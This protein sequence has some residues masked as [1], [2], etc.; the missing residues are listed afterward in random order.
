MRKKC[1]A[2]LLVL[3]MVCALIVP[4]SATNK[5]PDLEGHWAKDNM[6]DLVD[7]GLLT[8]DS[9]GK[10]YP[11]NNTTTLQ[12]LVML[13]RFYD[14]D[15][16]TL[17][18]VHKEHGDYVESKVEP[19]LEWAYSA[20]EICLAAQ[21]VSEKELV[22]LKLTSP[23]NKQTLS[24]FLIR[25]MQMTD[26]TKE[27]YAPLTFEDTDTIFSSYKPFGGVLVDNGII[28]GDTQ[29]KFNPTQSVTR[30]VIATMLSRSLE[31]ME[32]KGIDLEL[33]GYAPTTQHTALLTKIIGDTIQIRDTAGVTFQ[34]NV[35]SN[36]KITQNGAPSTL[37]YTQ[38]GYPIA[39]TLQEGVVVAADVT[40]ETD[41]TWAQGVMSSY[42]STYLYYTPL[43]ST[44]STRLSLDKDVTVIYNGEVTEMGSLGRNTMVTLKLEDEK[45]T[46]ITGTVA[47]YEIIGTIQAL[48][49][50][51]NV[52]M[53]VKDSDGTIFVFSMPIG[54][55]PAIYRGT[56]EVSVERLTLGDKVT[57]TVTDGTV[58]TIVT[59][60]EEGDVSGVI[61]GITTTASGTTWF[62]SDETGKTN[63]Y[64]VDSG[65][66]AYDGADSIALSSIALGDVVD[67]VLYD[68]MITVVYLMESET[69]ANK[70]TATVL[71][72]DQGDKLITAQMSSGSLVYVSTAKAGAVIL[73]STGKNYSLSS[74]DEGDKLVA[75]GTYTDVSSFQA[76]TVIIED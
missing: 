35:A 62:I 26:A 67:V 40:V 74:M 22:G 10:M 68:D 46:E 8:G 39:V 2:M 52:E 42:S 36:A 12:A 6:L 20:L 25:A 23:I 44:D 45:I 43:G 54:N 58:A 31:L 18:E 64:V 75:Y 56:L 48:N 30:G 4:A 53:K 32:D 65:A 57:V 14:L 38:Y 51:A 59:D 47:D 72:A 17:A 34:Y 11:D 19:S 61:T 33:E 21:I 13:S 3:T 70:I 69:N 1:I 76:S 60:A 28:T 73:A 41:V 63:S 49:L 50:G 66:V 7:R 27:D 5:F 71:H 16:T 15:K 37:G 9:D 24:V 55:L 29:N